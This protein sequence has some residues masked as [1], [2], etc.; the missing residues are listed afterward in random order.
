MQR[1][2]TIYFEEPHLNN[3][4]KILGAAFERIKGLNIAH[5][6]IA[7]NTGAVVKKA[8]EIFNG[9]SVCIV[10][11]TNRASST[12]PV[13]CLYEKYKNSREIKESFLKKDIKD[14]PISLPEETAKEFKQ[15]GIKV[16]HVPD[17]LGLGKKHG[18][19]DSHP[20]AREK[21]S[22]LVPKHLHPLDI[23]AGADLSML[24][25]LSMGFRVCV[26]ITA[27]AAQNALVPTGATVLA[28]AGTGWA[29][30]GADTAVVIEADPNPKACYVKEIIGLPKNK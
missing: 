2:K 24:N 5:V 6:I 19:T 27:V 11:V 4:E 29:G 30:G 9:Y 28:I 12:M 13:S 7:T 20:S 1:S 22:F 15:M 3:T 26:G 23:D 25:I 10:A 21:L 8:I 16:Y 14:F 17:S 18:E